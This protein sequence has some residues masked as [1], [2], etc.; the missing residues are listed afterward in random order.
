MYFNVNQS[1]FRP[2]HSTITATTLVVDDCHNFH[3]RWFLSLFGRCSAVGVVIL[4]AITIHFYFSVRFV[5]GSFTPGFHLLSFLCI[6]T[7][8]SRLGLCGIIFMLLVEDFH[9]IFT[10]VQC[11]RKSKERCFSPSVS[12]CVF[13][14]LI[15]TPMFIWYCT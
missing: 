13:P 11:C 12:D 2:G 10:C 7:P 1:G 4:L 3:R 5:F 6:F 8:V 9:S 14:C 15:M